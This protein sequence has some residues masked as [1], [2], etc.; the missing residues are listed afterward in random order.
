MEQRKT[1][2]FSGG[3]RAL[4]IIA[5]VIIILAAAFLIYSGDYYHA[6][7]HAVAAMT[8][9]LDIKV[10]QED[11]YTVYGDTT[12]PV[13]IVFYP[14]A[15]VDSEAYAPLMRALAGRGYC[16]A[17]ADMPLHLAIFG[18]NAADEIIEELPD[19]D[20]WYM[21]GHSMGGVF[22][23]RYADQNAD[24]VAGLILL[25]AYPDETVPESL[26]VLSIYGSEDTVLNKEKYLASKEYMPQLREE[27][28]EGGNHAQFGCYG[29][30]AG[31]SVASISPE[32]QWRLTA[33]CISEF[34]S[35]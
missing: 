2:R 32:E 23:A 11:G 26:K 29:E 16:C 4:V 19:V 18:G 15:K 12:A 5:A 13:G 21:A 30:Q 6:Q 27:I 25:A 17:V 31:D 33:D 35:E 1:R 34:I 10:A 7:E 14:G 24:S 20:R 3:L 22:A 9:E 28:I 8:E